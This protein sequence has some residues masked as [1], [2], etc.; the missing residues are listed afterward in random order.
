[1]ARNGLHMSYQDP[2]TWDE[3]YRSGEHEGRWHRKYPSRE[4]CTVV[5]AGLV[6][7]GG[8]VLDIGCGAGTEAIYLAQCG[9]RVTAIDF[10][11][12][13]IDIAGER[14]READVRVEWHTA[15]ALDLPVADRS[16]DFCFDRGCF[17]HVTQPDRPRYASEIARVLR[18][19]GRLFLRGYDPGDVPTTNIV[20]VTQDAIDRAFDPIRFARGRVEVLVPPEPED[21]NTFVGVFLTRL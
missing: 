6:P 15:S 14:A 21:P 11:A 13:A 4:L 3:R 19:G 5:A 18:T 1:V 8:R 10:S 17:H 9:F 20:P 12:S 7:A 16:I 2:S